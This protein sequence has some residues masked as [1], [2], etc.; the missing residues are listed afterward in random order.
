MDIPTDPSP[1]RR[2]RPS[3]VDPNLDA[4]P[5]MVFKKSALTLDDRHLEALGKQIADGVQARLAQQCNCLDDPTLRE[6]VA[7]VSM[8]MLREVI[9]HQRRQAALGC[10]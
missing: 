5:Q 8:Q 9:A 4:R 10:Q 6:V 2:V 7:A 1:R 3:W